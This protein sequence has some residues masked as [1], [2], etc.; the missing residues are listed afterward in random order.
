MSE[1]AN[2]VFQRI[3][4]VKRKFFHVSIVKFLKG[5]VSENLSTVNVLKSTYSKSAVGMFCQMEVDKKELMLF[6]TFMK[7][8][9]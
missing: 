2:L 8:I 4:S 9:Q 3:F 6:L 5:P 7:T 1:A